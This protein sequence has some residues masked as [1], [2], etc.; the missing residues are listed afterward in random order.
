MKNVIVILKG[1]V[2][3]SGETK[4]M[5]ALGILPSCRSIVLHDGHPL[6]DVHIFR[7]IF[8]TVMW[9]P[10]S[11]CFSFRVEPLRD[12][13]LNFL[14]SL[15]PLSRDSLISCSCFKPK[16]QLV[17]NMRA[18]WLFSRSHV[19]EATEFVWYLKE[20]PNA[21]EVLKSWSYFCHEV[22]L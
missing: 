4:V 20:W 14:C 13:R 19:A 17:R 15:H 18:S 10:D 5:Y 2:S 22:Y 8:N 1:F 12:P 3:C 21:W 16:T 11:S 9:T 6:V 7:N